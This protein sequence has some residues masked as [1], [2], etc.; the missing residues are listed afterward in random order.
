MDFWRFTSV[1]PDHLVEIQ[2]HFDNTIFFLSL[3]VAALSAYSALIVLERVWA[4]T[5]KRMQETWLWF[6]A[7]VLGSGV[8]AMHFTGMLAFMIPVRMSYD[9]LVTFIS[10]LPAIAASY[11]ALRILALRLFQFWWIQLGS[12]ILAVGIGSMHYIGMEA[13]KMDALMVYDPTLV[14]VSI[15]LAHILALI[16]LYTRILVQTNE[17]SHS[18]WR[19]ISA[20]IM[21]S[22]I[23]SMHYT[24]MEAASY[25]VVEGTL[26]DHSMMPHSSLTIALAIILIVV[27][28]VGITM[29]GSILERRLQIA[30]EAASERIAR[31]H[32]LIETLADGLIVIDQDSVIETFNSAAATIFQYNKAD[33]IGSQINKLIPKISY[34][35]L[36]EDAQKLNQEIIGK[37]TEFEGITSQNKPVP[38]EVTISEMKIGS[39]PIFNMVLR[40]TTERHLLEDQLRHAQK[41]ESIGQLAAG[42]A[43]EINTPVQ[44]VSDNISF[45]RKVFTGIL[46]VLEN[47]KIVMETQTDET[48]EDLKKAIKKAKLPFVTSEI[49]KALDQSIDGLERIATI[50]RAMKSFSHSSGDQMKE[51]DIKEA[52]ETTVTVARSEW[53]YVADVTCDFE[54]NLPLVYCL[55]DEFNQVVLNILVNAAHAIEDAINANQRDKGEIKLSVKKEDNCIAV[56]IADNGNGIP[57]EIQDKIFDPFFTTKEIGKGTGQG[58]SIAYNVIVEKHN[59]SIHVASEEGKGTTFKIKLPLTDN[60]E[61]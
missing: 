48:L 22:A 15:I 8:W 11:L 13:M 32:T 17:G 35:L 51:T 55:R 6:G 31:E 49:P 60:N 18:G 16:A 10:V 43:H 30:E 40:D 21:G 14:V 4:S 54:D 9:P 33:I 23:S 41:L 58:L 19:I 29:I 45:I 50:V 53:K 52:I 56:T 27:V 24:A 38:L 7:I 1:I 20:I 25:Y 3:L 46:N 42:I 47:S 2:G 59:G 61:T 5:N 36:L 44:Y 39:N 12:L 34:Q 37:T 28:F 57:K 26:V